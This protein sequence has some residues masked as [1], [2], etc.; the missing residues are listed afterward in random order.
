L[1]AGFHADKKIH[2]LIGE[3]A[4]FSDICRSIVD[5][6]AGIAIVSSASQSL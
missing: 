1:L 5:K 3:H 6:N 4:S 2:I